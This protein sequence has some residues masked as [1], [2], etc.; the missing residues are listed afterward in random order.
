MGTN[1]SGVARV[2]RPPRQLAL[3]ENE[4]FPL[5]A[6]E[7]SPAVADSITIRSAGR[8]EV[9]DPSRRTGNKWILRSNGAVGA[10]RL[11]NGELL[12]IEPKVSI[13]NLFRMLEYAYGLKEVA[14]PDDLVTAETLDDL[15]ERFALLLANHVLR[16]ANRGFVR[17]YEGRREELHA[18]RGRIRFGDRARKPSDVAL[19]CD[20]EEHTGD[21]E[22]NRILSWALH[23]VS[24]SPWCGARSRPRVRRALHCLAG[25]AP[26][27]PIAPDLCDD[28]TYHRLNADYEP[29]HCLARFFIQN[30]GPAHRRGEHA[31]FP[32]LIDMDALFELFV[33]RWL[34]QH[35]PHEFSLDEQRFHSMSVD[36]QVS[37][38]ID[39]VVTHRDTGQV[40]CVLDSKYKRS[41]RPDA[42]D[43]QQV[44]A[45]AEELGCEDALLVFPTADIEKHDFRGR[46]IR[47]RSCAF[48]LSG[49]L[50]ATGLR[51]L[52]AVAGCG[53]R[54]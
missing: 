30:C 11:D 3:R 53:R 2:N 1:R 40:L 37:F 13:E 31:T 18:L 38:R 16:R 32:F 45:Y 8:I 44:I 50:E 28:R 46:K 27:V 23:L 54:P 25:I 15:F 29:M 7:L 4:A 22:D 21:N 48:D 12:T 47:V 9:R 49:D 34:A 33:A 52:E 10:M 36:R 24:R 20:F 51:V 41:R 26:P 43:V 19:P 14:L 5:A 39:L 35:L 17:T 42:G 6:D